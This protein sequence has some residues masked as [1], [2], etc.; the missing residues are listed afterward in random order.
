VASREA[1]DLCG[2]LLAKGLVEAG[3]LWGPLRLAPEVFAARARD[4]AAR[5]L[6]RAGI[7]ATPETLRDVVG[8]MP[9]ADVALAIACAEGV[10]GAW[11]ALVARLRPRLEGLARRRGASDADAA[12]LAGDALAE[13]TVPAGP[14]GRRPIDTYDGA[15]SLFGWAAVILVRKLHR[16]RGRRRSSEADAVRTDDA[17]REP[18]QPA[19]GDPADALA[20][21]EGVVRFRRAL[22][23]AWADLSG[24]ERLALVCRY[25]DGTPQTRI[26][27]L[28]RVSEPHTSRILAAAVARL[29][30]GVRASLGDEAPGTTADLVEALRGHLVSARLVSP[31]AHGPLPEGGS[32]PRGTR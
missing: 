29:R 2:D 3:A 1:A 21:G 25:L 9:L 5:R 16:S 15:G 12:A 19:G 6:A 18:A 20:D 30:D 23:R 4:R 31:A 17:A 22:G 24:R 10:A 11:E 26:A 8:R 7:D 27:S 32:P 28:L 13:M 14:R